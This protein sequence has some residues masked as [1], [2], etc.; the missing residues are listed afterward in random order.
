MCCMSEFWSSYAGKEV[1]GSAGMV[2]VSN[3]TP[4]NHLLLKAD[5]VHSAKPQYFFLE[6]YQE[7]YVVEMQAFIDSIQKNTAPLVTGQDGLMPVLLGLA[8]KKSLQENRPVR[9]SEM[10]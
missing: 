5:G 3:R 7:A 10:D 9:V 6:R 8:A 2:S 4:D 1:F